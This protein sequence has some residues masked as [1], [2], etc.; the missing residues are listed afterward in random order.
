MAKRS[1]DVLT[2][3]VADSLRNL[4]VLKGKRIL[5]ALSGPAMIR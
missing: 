4:P 2:D 3:R 1:F 5:L